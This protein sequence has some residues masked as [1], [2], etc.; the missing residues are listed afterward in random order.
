MSLAP[1]DAPQPEQLAQ[2]IHDYVAQAEA[3]LAKNDAPELSQLYDAVAAL[4]NAVKD[5]P[6]AQ[7]K[8]YLEMLQTLHA[9]VDALGQSIQT[10]QQAIAT[11]LTS[12][13][14]NKKAATAYRKQTTEKP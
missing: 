3:A 11:E 14:T 12:L 8:P 9:R 10:G 13:N 5:L 4:C 7:A 2:A 1:D 6:I